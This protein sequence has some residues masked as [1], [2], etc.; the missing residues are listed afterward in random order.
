[1]SGIGGLGVSGHKWRF[2]RAGGFDQVR[3]D[4]GT[5][6]MALDQLD[7]KLWVCLSSPT[8]GLDF[9]K[10]TLQFLDTDKDGRIKVQEV[11]DAARWACSVL[12]NPDDLTMGASALP[13]NA[14]N[15][16]DPDG[17]RVLSM[18]RHVLATLGKGESAAISLEDIADTSHIF[19]HMKFNGDGIIPADSSDDPLLK[20]VILEIIDCIGPERDRSGK[21]GINQEKVDQFFKDAEA[22]SDW[23]KKGEDKPARFLPLGETTAAAY[24]SFIDVRKK[25]D[26]YFV[27]CRMAAFDPRSIPFLNRQET[28]YKDISIRDIS[29]SA[30]DLTGFPVSE[31]GT[32]DRPLHLSNRINPAWTARILKFRDEVAKPII[33][34]KEMMTESDWM[35][36]SRSFDEYEKW[37]G[38]KSGASVE[39]LGIKRLR[40]ILAG[41]VREELCKLIEK[42]MSLEKHANAISDVERLICYHANLH[43]FLNNFVSFRDFYSG[44]TKAIFQAGTLYLDGRSCDL[45]VRVE[46]MGKHIA[47]AGLSKIYLA[48]CECIRRVTGEK[49]TIAAAFTDGDA[50]FLLVGRNGLFYDRLG[51]DWDATILKI[52]EHPISIREAFWSPY[53]RISR[54][55]GEQ[56]EKFA[57]SKDKAVSDRAA[58]GVEGAMKTADFGKAPEKPAPFDIAKF[59][60]IFA[61]IGLAFGAIG[62]VIAVTVTGFL[63]LVWWQM[64][65]A[66]AGIVLIISGPSMLLAWLKLRQRSLSPILDACGWAVN[67]RATI[68][69]PFG[70]SLTGIASIPEGAERSLEDPY[71]EKRSPWPK[72]IF[73]LVVLGIVILVLNKTG[74]LHKMIGI[75]AK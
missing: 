22:Y 16:T 26:D 52:I 32:A 24:Q 74:L 75:V 72:I 30:E 36:I 40:E 34:N 57:A 49:I 58:A 31:I 11:L 38:T 43:T 45:C 1:M 14:I 41:N 73:L 62:S 46:D 39:K 61:A 37:Q 18:S 53:R 64:P 17:E 13:L 33:G 69:I 44:K 23:W 67:S 4:S 50:N 65:L 48:Y 27:R 28:D 56:M 19:S 7:Q 55:V 35:T 63:K 47:L 25:L 70:A 6:I 12:K 20:G 68:N 2:F 71:A 21:D 29:P 8:S 60:G 54:M 59:A 3:L 5:D 42:D 51:R 66:V 10:K 9:D 15:D